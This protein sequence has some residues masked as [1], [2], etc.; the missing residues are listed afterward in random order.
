MLAQAFA[1]GS[2]QATYWRDIAPLLAFQC[3]HC[4][5]AP[6]GSAA[7]GLSTAT[8]AALREGGN[9]GPSIL[10]GDPDRSLLVEYLDGRRQRRMP[11]EAPPLEPVAIALIRRWIAEGAPEG[12]APRWPVLEKNRVDMR[13]RRLSI[14]CTAPRR[15]Y[16]IVEVSDMRN[17]TL[18]RD[19]RALAMGGKTQWSVSAGAGWP[20]RVTVRVRFA[21]MA[22]EIGA[23]T[24]DVNP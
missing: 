24:L 3:N 16:L 19:E 5:A 6:P 9:T 11:L 12:D 13:S 1:Q 10:A 2:A 4:H 8:Y 14:S 18:F 21:H 20:K 17:R 23:A 7:G 15:A 22:G